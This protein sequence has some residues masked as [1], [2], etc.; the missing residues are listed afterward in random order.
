MSK[1]RIEK[2]KNGTN[3]IACNVNSPITSIRCVVNVGSSSEQENLN[4]Y[5]AAHFL[6]HMFFKGTHNKKYEEI[7]SILGKIGDANAYTSTNKTV[8]R[9]NTI[10][11]AKKITEGLDILGEM[12]YESSMPIDEIEK[13]KGT[14]IQEWQSVQDSSL[15]YFFNNVDQSYIG[16]LAHP[17]IGTKDSIVDMTRDTLIDFKHRVYR[18][19]N[20][21]FCIVGGIDEDTAMQI[22]HR[23]ID[24]RENLAQEGID[25]DIIGSIQQGLDGINNFKHPSEQSIVSL[26]YPWYSFEE[27]RNLNYAPDIALNALGGGMHSLIFDRIREKLGLA[28][29]TGCFNNMSI[30]VNSI[31]CYGLCDK[32]KISLIIE[33]IEKIIDQVINDGIDSDLFN[34]ASSN[35]QFN[36]ISGLQTISQISSYTVDS[37][38]Y[39]RKYMGDEFDSVDEL[40]D[41]LNRVNHVDAEFCFNKL[42]N[43]KP[44]LFTQNGE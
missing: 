37:Y 33:E 35:N 16:P 41:K 20:I 38:F 30:G 21:A 39:N 23:F 6:E 7:N 1:Y 17:V 31:V 26:W 9:I 11:N 10:S 24:E 18:P 44:I 19:N 4:E 14:I 27:K 36:T 2:A 28:Y 25:E 12:L 3:L 22:L 40:I 29:S 5:G 34:T 13:E 8:Y 15:S 43:V 42:K 32:S